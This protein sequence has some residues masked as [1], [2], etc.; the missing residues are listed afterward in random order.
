M[1]LKLQLIDGTNTQGNNKFRLDYD[2]YFFE[3]T[4]SCACEKF[5]L[6]PISEFYNTAIQQ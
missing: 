6:Q 5:V 1:E 4:F 2:Y 3:R